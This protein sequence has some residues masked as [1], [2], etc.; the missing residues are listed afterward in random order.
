MFRILAHGAN[1]PCP[2]PA[3]QREDGEKIGRIQRDV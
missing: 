2:P 1:Q 3:L